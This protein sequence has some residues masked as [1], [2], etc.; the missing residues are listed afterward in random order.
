MDKKKSL[1][2]SLVIPCFNE[3]NNVEPLLDNLED[4]SN[5][6]D[7]PL[8]II[9]VDGD[10]D[11]GTDRILKQA[12]TNLDSN[13]FKL[14]LLN[15][16]KGYGF[17]ILQ[18]LKRT[19]HEVLAWTHA[20]LQTDVKDV[21][22]AYNKII[23]SRKDNLVIKGNRK[24]RKILDAFLTFGMQIIVLFYLRTYLTDINAQP[25]VFRRNFYENFLKKNAPNDFSL[26]LFTLY[27]AKKNNHSI[28]SIPVYF[29]KR[30]HGIAKGGGGSL[31]NRLN[32]IKR[33]FKYIREL[34]L[35]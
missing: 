31:R 29:K 15:T 1:G 18:G 4:L 33:T 24:K 27:A 25:K 6:I 13:I 23:S 20:D 14:I 2:L 28:Q 21:E 16:K 32:L 19:K 9:I 17:D 11:D 35:P 30:I 12:F 10:S 34:S 8:E 5:S 3:K 26:D 7:F 22:R